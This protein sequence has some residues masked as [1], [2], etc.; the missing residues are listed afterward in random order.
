[1]QGIRLPK[2]LCVVVCGAAHDP[3]YMIAINELHLSDIEDI[4]TPRMPRKSELNPP[5]SNCIPDGCI[6]YGVD[7]NGELAKQDTAGDWRLAG[8][9]V[10]RVLCT[11]VRAIL[12]YYST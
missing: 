2:D 7:K 3:T 8:N 9:D 11:V 6:D 5:D 1:M 4:K 12:T 10:M